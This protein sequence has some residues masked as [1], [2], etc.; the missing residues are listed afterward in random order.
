MYTN[1]TSGG[2]KLGDWFGDSFRPRLLTVDRGRLSMFEINGP[3]NLGPLYENQNPIPFNLQG[4]R[5]VPNSSVLPPPQ[6]NNEDLVIDINSGG[7]RTGDGA[8]GPTGPTGPTGPA[9]PQGPPGPDGADAC[10]CALLVFC[11]S[12]YYNTSKCRVTFEVESYAGTAGDGC[13]DDLPNISTAWVETSATWNGFHDSSSYFP[14]GYFSFIDPFI[15]NALDGFGGTDYDNGVRQISESTLAYEERYT[16]QTGIT[17]CGGETYVQV[18]STCRPVCAKF[19]SMAA[20]TQETSGEAYQWYATRELTSG[21][22]V[23]SGTETVTEV[24][25]DDAVTVLGDTGATGISTTIA[26]PFL[27]NAG[28]G[29]FGSGPLAPTSPPPLTFITPPDCC[30]TCDVA[31][32]GP[33]GGLSAGRIS[34]LAEVATDPSRCLWDYADPAEPLTLTS[35]G[36]AATVNAVPAMGPTT[37][38]LTMEGTFSFEDVTVDNQWSDPPDCGERINTLSCTWSGEFRWTSSISLFF[39]EPT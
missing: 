33:G 8:A 32:P 29:A 1:D 22:Y 26:P 20:D 19:T 36:G 25:C 13:C 23:D 10:T 24:A 28:P 9:G 21:G 5:A 15:A 12:E 30:S 11:S 4:Y 31:G 2:R 37:W 14:V 17:I 16:E 18:S 38:T 3:L 7:G 35:S 39:V 27:C 34:E 6:G